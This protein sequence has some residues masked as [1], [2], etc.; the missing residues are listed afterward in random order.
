TKALGDL[1]SAQSPPGCLHVYRGV[2][3]I[4]FTAQPGQIIRFGQ[5]TSCS[6]KKDKAKQFGN[7]TFFEVDTCHGAAIRDFS[8]YPEEE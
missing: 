6:L 2:R 7:D 4:R 8:F 5:F 1:R 3:G